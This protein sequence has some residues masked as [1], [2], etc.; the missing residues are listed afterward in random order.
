MTQRVSRRILIAL[1]MSTLHLSFGCVAD[2]PPIVIHEEK[3]LSVWL[4]F[5]PSSGTGHSHPA[6]ISNDQLAVILRG[7]GVQVRDN[8]AGF[9]MFASKTGSPAFLSTEV[10]V[11]A[12]FLAQA[13]AKASP[14]DMVTFYL[15]T[16]DLAR[17][18]LVTSGGLF[19]RG[20]HLYVILANAHSSKFSVQYENVSAID[21]RDQPLLPIARYRFSAAFT[22][23]EAWIPNK[24]VRG[25]DGY[26]RYFDESKLVV[27][28][29]DRLPEMIEKDRR[30]NPT[31]S[32]P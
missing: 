30:P 5:D 9:G 21:T 17:G 6:T 15:V 29:L 25:N 22:P 31:A 24:Q 27:V 1:F 32:R 20:R 19:L 18:D 4:K 8:I 23:Q 3:P 12:P 10:T 28:D 14:K 2:S 11:L 7:V 13:F 26:D 16:P